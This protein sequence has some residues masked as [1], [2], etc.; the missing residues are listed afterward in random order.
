MTSDLCFIAWMPVLFLAAWSNLCFLVLC[1]VSWASGDFFLPSCPP[2]TFIGYCLALVD[3]LEYLGWI[4]LSSHT[5]PPHFQLPLSCAQSNAECLR[6]F[7]QTSFLA[8]SYWQLILWAQWRSGASWGD[9]TS[10]WLIDLES[11]G[12]ES[13][14]NNLL[15]FMLSLG[16]WLL[17]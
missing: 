7:S 12:F 8:P 1:L 13:Y 4:S 6:N 10:F 5:L 2:L 14:Q 9:L 15:C 17:K 11:K 16:L 3:D